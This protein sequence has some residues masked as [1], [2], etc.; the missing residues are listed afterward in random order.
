M[1]RIG[2]EGPKL[3]QAPLDMYRRSLVCALT[4]FFLSFVAQSEDKVTLKKGERA[5]SLVRGDIPI[6]TYHTADVP[7]PKGVDPAYNRSGFIYPMHAPSGGIVTGIH[8][9][10]HYHHIGLWHAW[11]K[12]KYKGKSPDFWNLGKKTGLVRHVKVI[13]TSDAGF[14]AELEQ[15]AFLEGKEATTVLKETLAVDAKYEAGANVIDYVLTQ[16]NITKDAIEFPANRYGGGIAYRGPH[17]W[18]AKNSDYLTSEGKKRA[19][20]HTT[21]ARWVAMFGPAEGEGKAGSD[22]TVVIMCHPENHDAPQRIR[23]WDDGR[24]FFNYVPVQETGWAL[25]PGENATLRYRIVILDGRPDE[26]D[27]EKRWKDYTGE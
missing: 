6:L 20:S 2:K 3:D 4:L 23:T 8:P 17:G 25:Q 27:L 9:D 16:E 26:K 14:T 11:V 22:A 1:E 21:R 19:D 5:L 24:V 15:A 12:T 13:E 18:N 7:P 10:D